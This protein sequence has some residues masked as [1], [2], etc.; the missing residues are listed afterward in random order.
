MEDN[1]G[2]EKILC[3]LRS[4]DFF[5]SIVYNSGELIQ[6]LRKEKNMVKITGD[7]HGEPI[8]L[9]ELLFDMNSG[10]TL[11]VTGDFGYVMKNNYEE[12]D[13]LD[14]IEDFDVNICFCDGNHENFDAI[15]ACEQL[16]WNGGK[17]HKIRKN[18]FHL[19]RGQVFT[20]EGAKYFTM[21]GAYSTDRYMRTKGIGWWERELPDNDEYNEASN[22]LSANQ[23]EVDYIIT[24]TAPKEIISMMGYDPINRDMELT[25]FLEWVMY[26]VKYKRWFF[27]H[28]HEDREIGKKFRALMFD[29]III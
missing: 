3:T 1:I 16:M 27:G 19:M 14:Q 18:I 10:D 21:G 22:N 26:S 2:V 15:E 24:H 5:Y 23:M 29:E 4:L 6:L 13:F 11:I 25:G 12:R 7:T 17:V 20:I 9:L 8:R 28:F